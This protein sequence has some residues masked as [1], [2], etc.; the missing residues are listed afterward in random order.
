MPETSSR[1]VRAFE[2]STSVRTLVLRRRFP[3]WITRNP[4]ISHRTRSA[5]ADTTGA[6]W[7]AAEEMS[8][9]YSRSRPGVRGLFLDME[10]SAPSLY[11]RL[12]GAPAI[13]AVVD[14][15]YRGILGDTELA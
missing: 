6:R 4:D 14:E 15:L 5:G 2:R 1:A 9:A 13:E 10:T 11:E 3:E 8:R 7:G 12:G